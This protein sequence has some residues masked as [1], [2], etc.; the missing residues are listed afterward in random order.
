MDLKNKN[1]LFI[2]P[3][4][5]NYENYIKKSL[6]SMGADV[7][8]IYE[9]LVY[10]SSTYHYLRKFFPTI[11]KKVAN[12][13]FYKNINKINCEK[14]DYVL[15]IRGEFLSVNFISFL[16]NKY[17][18]KCKFIL[19]QWDSIINNPNAIVISPYFDKCLSFDLSDAKKYSWNY[20]PL[21][22]INRL[23][24]PSLEKKYDMLFIG[25]MHSQRVSIHYLIKK[26]CELNRLKYY[27][28]IFSF[29]IG[30]FKNKYF[31]RKKEFIADID[32]DVR[33]STLSLEECYKLY[34]TSRI[35]VDY[36]H[37]GQSGLTM[38]TVEALGCGC[39]MVTNNEAIMSSDFYNPNNIY[40]YDSTNID[41]PLK[42]IETPYEEIDKEI[43]RTYSLE[44]WIDEVFR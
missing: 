7:Y 16:R 17:G 38:R 10:F 39:K 42:F 8:L 37:P 23:A 1:V 26:F 34:N 21:F 30:Y 15:V 27:S 24:N 6:E 35:L 5:F 2:A 3:K 12:N 22:Y 32:N 4:Y 25:S 36:A 33:F 44:Y 20:R 40:I 43:V 13:Y 31:L 18:D 28:H 29:R 9:N 41:I 14:I 11:F 19:Y